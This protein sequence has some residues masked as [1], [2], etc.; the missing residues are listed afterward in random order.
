MA[1]RPER[2]TIGEGEQSWDAKADL[3]FEALVEGPFPIHTEAT[4]G[5]LNT[6]FPPANYEE[7]IVLVG[8]VLYISDGATWGVY[9]QAANVPDSTATTVAD[10]ATDFNT[11]LSALQTAGIMATS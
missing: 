6:N 1:T 7:C 9:I 8:G 4:I 2:L 5:D 11:L 3:N 10:M